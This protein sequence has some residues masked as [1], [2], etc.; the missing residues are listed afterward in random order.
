MGLGLPVASVGVPEGVPIP[1]V[2][3]VV[4]LGAG[5][6]NAARQH[7]AQCHGAGYL[8]NARPGNKQ[9]L[10]VC[11]HVGATITLTTV[12]PV[13]KTMDITNSDIL[14]YRFLHN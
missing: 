14:V 8:H 6:L 9:G 5:V 12:W 2:A 3:G 1:A 7:H 10:C 13:K 11:K 4:S